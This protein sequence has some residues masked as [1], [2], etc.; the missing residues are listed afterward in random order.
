MSHTDIDGKLGKALY[1]DSLAKTADRD[2]I[3]VPV[4]PDRGIK[5]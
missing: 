2:R 3:V 4:K 1:R 5:E